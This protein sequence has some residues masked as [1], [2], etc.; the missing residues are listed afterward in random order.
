M[1]SAVLADGHISHANE[2]G[3]VFVIKPNPEQLELVVKNQLGD[4]L[5]RLLSPVIVSWFVPPVTMAKLVAR[6]CIRS[7]FECVERQDQFSVWIFISKAFC[8]PIIG[9]SESSL[10]TNICL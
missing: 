1:S 3:K 5:Q 7:V 2:E 9:S 10:L 4:D 6:P 8:L